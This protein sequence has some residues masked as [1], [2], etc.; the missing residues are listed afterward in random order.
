MKKTLLT[1]L[2]AGSLSLA[3][4][5]E[6]EKKT[7]DYFYRSMQIS[8]IALNTADY[9]LTMKALENGGIEKNPLMKKITENKLLCLGVKA[10]LTGFVLYAT[11]QMYKDNPKTA[12]YILL[13]AN[14]FY[15]AVITNNISVSIKLNRRK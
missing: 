3:N 7:P 1:I 15:S 13:G 14:I 11:N 12:R 5:Q 6:K 10:G 8:Y 4:A 2:L 9:I